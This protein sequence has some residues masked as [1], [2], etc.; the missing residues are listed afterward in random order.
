MPDFFIPKEIITVY[1][2]NGGVAF[3]NVVLK[4]PNNSNNILNL[5]YPKRYYFF[6][7][8]FVIKQIGIVSI[9]GKFENIYF[10]AMYIGYKARR[11]SFSGIV[12]TLN[13][14]F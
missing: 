8:G 2:A 6:A 11:T 5:G 9:Y 12:V 1:T 4:Y 13:T 14:F 3:E 7:T 10:T